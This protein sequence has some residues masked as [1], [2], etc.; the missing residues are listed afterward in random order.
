MISFKIK[1]KEAFNNF[2]GDN[3]GLEKSS[4][5]RSVRLCHTT[6]GRLYSCYLNKGILL[7]FCI[8]KKLKEISKEKDL[9]ERE[10]QSVEKNL[11]LEK[12]VKLLKVKM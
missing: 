3:K 12:L 4:F 8:F 2:P 7:V 11:E 9:E 5:R 1:G 6:I 10:A